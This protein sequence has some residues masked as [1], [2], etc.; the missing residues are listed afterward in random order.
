[1]REQAWRSDATRLEWGKG[2]MAKGVRWRVGMAGLARAGIWRRVRAWQAADQVE[3][4]AV[5]D[6]DPVRRQRALELGVPRVYREP[7]ELLARES[8]DLVHVA[9]NPAHQGAL[10]RS[11]LMRG[12]DVVVE[13]PVAAHAGEMAKLVDA[14]RRYGGL[15]IPLWPAFLDPPWREALAAASQ[16]GPPVHL[17]A[18]HVVGLDP[19]W[20]ELGYELSDDPQAPV[21][22]LVT[23]GAQGLV[24]L[25]I[26]L[27]G[28]P[29]AVAAWE[30]APEPGWPWGASA[31][32]MLLYPQASARLRL[33][34]CQTGGP[35][36]GPGF[37]L[38]AEEGRFEGRGLRVVQ[39]RAEGR[40]LHRVLRRE[41]PLQPIV[42]SLAAPAL[43]PRS[44]DLTALSVVGQVMAALERSAAAAGNVQRLFP[45]Q[46][47]GAS[48][49]DR[50]VA[51]A[52]AASAAGHP[53]EEA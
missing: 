2:P 30:E 31:T 4:V 16:V 9:A 32:L 39:E 8:L 38:Y 1:M 29:A 23:L 40:H 28:A 52:A 10:I 45:P 42:Q 13:P 53:D 12:L 19:W 37:T 50:S 47:Q 11:A 44:L 34:W 46:P 21:P 36:R 43:L 22:R 35:M 7:R 25:A 41:D 18:V 49:L 51:A 27:L 48:P 15:L 24:H 3:L 6:R 20:E 33:A 14:S 5:A 26:Q 17:D